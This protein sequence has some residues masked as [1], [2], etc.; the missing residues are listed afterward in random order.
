MVGT[1][2]IS[3]E[4]NPYIFDQIRVSLPAKIAGGT[5]A[6]VG[7]FLDHCFVEYRVSGIEYRV[8]VLSIRY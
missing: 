5:R 2:P 8:I 6:C 3:M 1:L 7:G 4:H